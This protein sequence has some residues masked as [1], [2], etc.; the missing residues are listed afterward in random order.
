MHQS[1]D[2]DW[3]I[4]QKAKTRYA[5]SRPISHAKTQNKRMEEDLPTKWSKRERKKAGVA[6]LVSDKIDFKATDQ[7]RQ[8]RA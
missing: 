5:A 3:Q 7:K 1:K 6:I 4:G 2:T 8:R